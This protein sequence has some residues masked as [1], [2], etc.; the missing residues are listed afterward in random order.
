[1]PISVERVHAG[2]IQRGDGDVIDAVI[3]FCGLRGSSILAEHYDRKGF[4]GVLNDYHEITAGGFPKAAAKSC[5][6]S[7][8]PHWRSS[9][10][11]AALTKEQP[12]KRRWTW[13]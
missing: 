2:Q 11:N 3:L 1:M 6:R 10:S 12:A 8:T 4:L 9:S 7:T 5:A 13:P